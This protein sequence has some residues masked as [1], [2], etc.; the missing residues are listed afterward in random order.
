MLQ[1]I[2]SGRKDKLG[3]YQISPD[4]VGRPAGIWQSLGSLL[5]RGAL[6]CPLLMAHDTEILSLTID[7]SFLD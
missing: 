2:T 4:S 7:Q 5:I 6:K 3:D 1:L